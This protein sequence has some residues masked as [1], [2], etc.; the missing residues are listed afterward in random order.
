MRVAARAKR[1]T[2]ARV[3]V[4]LHDG[5]VCIITL[6]EPGLAELVRMREAIGAGLEPHLA[7]LSGP[8]RQSL[9]DGIAVMQRL[10]TTNNTTTTKDIAP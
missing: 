8:D 3:S 7:R 1:S 5:R 4:K 2:A 9:A 10:M 6:T